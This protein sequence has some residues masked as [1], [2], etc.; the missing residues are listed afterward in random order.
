M[1]AA[2]ISLGGLAFIL[3]L[4]LGVASKIFAVE[5]DPTV[6]A[7]AEVLPGANCGGCGYAGCAGFAEAVASGQTAPTECKAAGSDIVAQMAQILGV[8]IEETEKKV[9]KIFCQG[10]SDNCKSK[11][12]YEGVFDCRAAV[13]L[14][15]GYKACPY[16]CL[17]YGSCVKACPFGAIEIGPKGLPI[18]DEQKC[19]GCG[20]CIRQCPRGILRL[21]PISQKYYIPCSSK[22][23]GKAVRQVCQ[24]GCLAC[25]LCLKKC[26]NQAIT[27]ENNQPRIDAQKCSGCGVCAEKCPK[28]II[29][30]ASN[31]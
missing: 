12:L 17:G 14:G 9:V 28:K 25:K 31:G 30:L 21:L 10:S 5:T 15:G 6:E 22:D 24:T 2:V 4:G 18:V 20:S 27:I 13:L 23:K 11:F 8:K 26:P 3:A 19:T 1:L 29:Q 16:S 7:I